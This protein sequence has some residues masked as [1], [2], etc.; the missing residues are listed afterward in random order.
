MLACH[1]LVARSLLVLAIGTAAADA[2][3]LSGSVRGNGAPLT[4]AA[5]RVLEID[6]LTTTGMDG[7]FK[8]T[9]VP[10][11]TYTVVATIDGYAAPRKEV[12]V[13]RGAVTASF[14]LRPSAIA[15][16]E[17]VVSATPTPRTDAN[18]Y[19]SV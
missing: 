4:G 18:Q 9:D 17:I 15:L 1:R 14:D 16:H 5:V 2:Q 19:Q 12:Q 13:P 6:R 10:A 8:F 11:G 3:T 7:E